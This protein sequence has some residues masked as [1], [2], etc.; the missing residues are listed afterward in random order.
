[1]NVMPYPIGQLRGIRLLDDTQR[2]QLFTEV[3]KQSRKSIVSMQLW[4]LNRMLATPAPLQEKMTLFFHGHFTSAAIEKNAWPNYMYAQN[5]LY[6]ENALGNLRDLTHAVSKD[7]AMLI[8]LD[9][10]TSNKAHPN[11]NYARELMELF[12]LGHGNYSEEDIRQSA[13]AFT[14]FSINRRSGTFVFNRGAHDD[15]TKTFLGRTGNFDGDDIVDIIYQQPACAK[16]WATTLLSYFVYD[17]PEPALVDAFAN[18]ITRNDFDLA[19]TMSALLQSNV[20]FS[21]RAYRARV[22]S[23]VEFVVGAHKTFGVASIEPR[24][25]RALPA[26]GQVLFHPPNVAGWPGGENWVTTQTIIAR[27]NFAAALAQ[28]PLVSESTWLGQI[29]TESDRAAY[30]LADGILQSDAPAQA[31]GQL[32]AYVSGTNDIRGAAYL[33]MAMPAYQLA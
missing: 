11:E 3:R 33:T 30:Q 22:K 15:G 9:N 13:R 19:P 31:L 25:L 24:S 1:D 26:M 27:E 18:T 28:S 2:R 12:T 4:W 32:V 23:P 16:F 14:G 7:P 5:Q 8:Y 29:P 20:F 10:A 6:R 21:P 17:N